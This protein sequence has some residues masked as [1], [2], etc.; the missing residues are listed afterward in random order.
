MP[1]SEFESLGSTLL[2]HVELPQLQSQEDLKELQLLAESGGGEV[3]YCV[4]CKRETLDPS[5]FIGSGKVVE[6]ADAVKAYD[7][8]TVIFNNTQAKLLIHI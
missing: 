1:S 4:C 3:A 7:V 5:T 6:V 8:Q 2:V